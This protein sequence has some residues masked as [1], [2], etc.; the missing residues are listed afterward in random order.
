MSRQR[1]LEIRHQLDVH[2]KA[3]AEL[4][5]EEDALLSTLLRIRTS[6]LKF[7]GDDRTVRWSSGAARLGLKARLFLKTLYETPKR[8]M[9]TNQL[10]RIVWNDELIRDNTVSVAVTRL[11]ES[12]AGA[13][14]PYE[15]ESVVCRSTGMR[16]GFRLKE[17]S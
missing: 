10:A 17:R 5:T 9:K 2:Y 16:I 11:N 13:K 7:D 12:L 15:I 6:A 14:C 1:L 8:R 3:I 4:R